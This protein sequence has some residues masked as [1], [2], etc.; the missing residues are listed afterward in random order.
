MYT[1][2]YFIPYISELLFLEH[3]ISIYIEV[4]E[5]GAIYMCDIQNLIGKSTTE[6]DR[7]REYDRR[8]TS[9]KKSLKTKR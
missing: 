3:C 1:I 4:L 8:M 2:V 5:N 9:E 6:A 7:K